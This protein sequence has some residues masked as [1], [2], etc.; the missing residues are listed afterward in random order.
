MRPTNARIWHKVVFKVGPVAKA[1]NTFEPV[2]IPVF[3]APPA[4]GN[5]PTPPKGVKTRGDGPLR[6][7]ELPSAEAHPAEPPRGK[8]AYR[9]RP[10]NWRGKAT[11]T[12][13][14]SG[15]LCLFVAAS[16]QTRLDIRS[17][18][19]RPIKV[20]I[21]RR[22]RSGTSRDSNPARLCCSSAHFVQCEPDEA[23]SFA[24]PNVGPGTYARL[25]LEL[26][27]KV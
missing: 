21:K 24:N 19:R 13:K 4:S 25:W 8:T 14:K 16:H 18:A 20:G 23:S 27:T 15:D 17:K 22:G 26:D 1:K 5:K 11:H 7:E 9:M 12:L 6:P 10:N 2:G 3:R